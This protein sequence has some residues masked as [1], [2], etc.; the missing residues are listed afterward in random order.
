MVDLYWH[1]KALISHVVQEKTMHQQEIFNK[2][3]S[4]DN[5]DESLVKEIWVVEIMMEEQNSK[6][7]IPVNGP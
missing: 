7:H 1:N 5:K 6:E 3:D 2:L 4:L